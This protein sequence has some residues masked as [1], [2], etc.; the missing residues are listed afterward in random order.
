MR[1]RKGSG[2]EATCARRI[3]LEAWLAPFKKYLLNSRTFRIKNHFS[4][5]ISE[6]IGSQHLLIGIQTSGTLL[7]APVDNE[8]VHHLS[9]RQL[10]ILKPAAGREGKRPFASMSCFIFT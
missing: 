8:T 5:L 3:K 7:K 6:K 10:L 4:L 2:E 1:D 9:L